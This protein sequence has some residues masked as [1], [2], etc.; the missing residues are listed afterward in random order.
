MVAF[1]N[2]EKEEHL[3]AIRKFVSMAAEG[4]VT[5]AGP[6]TAARI[7]KAFG[8]AGLPYQVHQSDALPEGLV[9]ALVDGCHGCIDMPG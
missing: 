2:P 3:A 8:K 5:V 4:Y 7:N 9:Y 1:E 6:E